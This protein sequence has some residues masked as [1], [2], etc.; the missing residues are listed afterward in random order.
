MASDNGVGERQ[1]RPDAL[2]STGISS[3]PTQM[4]RLSVW[5]GIQT[6]FGCS[7][8]PAFCRQVAS[9]AATGQLSAFGSLPR[10]P[11]A[12]AAGHARCPRSIHT[13][14][15]VPQIW[16]PDG[17]RRMGRSFWVAPLSMRGR[18]AC[19]RGPIRTGQDPMGRPAGD[20]LTS[21]WCGYLGP[22]ALGRWVGFLLSC[23]R[24]PEWI[25]LV[26]LHRAAGDALT[27]DMVVLKFVDP[28]DLNL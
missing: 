10:G 11:A 13:D 25:R 15:S 8:R 14:A 22:F 6:E 5:V 19:P 28:Y 24:R 2:K 1:A 27:C 26:H 16:W 3:G 12:R 20:A 7:R 4:V 21:I 23:P 18:S 9:N 17:S